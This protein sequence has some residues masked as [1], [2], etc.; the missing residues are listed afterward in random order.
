M[1]RPEP[2]VQDFTVVSVIA[3]CA[4]DRS[5]RKDSA[6]VTGKRFGC[7][8]VNFAVHG[9][10]FPH[11]PGVITRMPAEHGDHIRQDSTGLTQRQ[12]D[13]MTSIDEAAPTDS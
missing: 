5:Q 3:D 12:A 9:V 11:R 8:D 7:F 13:R 1:Q 6:T 4:D 2:P 10:A